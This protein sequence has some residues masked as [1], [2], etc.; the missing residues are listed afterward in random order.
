MPKVTITKDKLPPINGESESYF[1]RFRIISDD[2][3]NKS[4]WSPI[5]QI[6]VA[7]CPP[8]THSATGTVGTI[9]GTGPWTARLTGL[10][11][12]SD[13]PVGSKICATDG[14][15]SLGTGGVYLISSILSNS[16]IEFTATG[17]TT[18]IAG[19]IANLKTV[20]PATVNNNS[21]IV[22]VVW[23]PVAE[24]KDYDVWIAW[25]DGTDP[26]TWLY[27]QRT[28]STSAIFAV[29]AGASKISIRVYR[30][31]E[32]ITQQFSN[33]KLYEILDQN[34]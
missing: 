2:R 16:S 12:T 32:P 20:G 27:L 8:Y 19:T 28:T 33:F 7:Y 10:N 5:Y 23:A 14:T 25:D 15:G 4:Y 34:V 11:N 21:G 22:S 18:P 13:L 26:S 31:V 3:N 9:T 6:P 24:V 1:T 17:G 29:E 30:P